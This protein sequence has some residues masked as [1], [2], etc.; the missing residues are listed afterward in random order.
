MYMDQYVLISDHYNMC[1][2]GYQSLG[3][4][5]PK[6]LRLLQKVEKPA[7]RPVTPT[8]SAPE[9]GVEERE[10]AII[11]LQRVLRGRSRQAKVNNMSIIGYLECSPLE[12]VD[13]GLS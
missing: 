10:Q 3:H 5:P 7:L 12:K 13:V 11:L 4:E 2:A 6:P 8:C 1:I 9:P